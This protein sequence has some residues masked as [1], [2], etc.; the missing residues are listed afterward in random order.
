MQSICLED[1]AEEERANV[2][3][4][5]IGGD[6]KRQ[7]TVGEESDSSHFTSEP[8]CPASSPLCQSEINKQTNKQKIGTTTTSTFHS[9]FFHHPN[10]HHAQHQ[11]APSN[12]NRNALQVRTITA[13]WGDGNL[14]WWR[15][16]REVAWM[17]WEACGV[18]WRKGGVE[19]A[20]VGYWGGGM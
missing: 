17:K 20:V 19:A 4:W 12:I 6:E 8:G 13:A 14:I 10:R 3:G 9:P 5:G 1:T 7:T 2:R 11:G 15:A 16:L 18:P